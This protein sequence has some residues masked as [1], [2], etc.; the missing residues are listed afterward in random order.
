MLVRSHILRDH[1]LSCERL[2]MRLCSDA[3]DL[4]DSHAGL[5]VLHVCFRFCK[6]VCG[7]CEATVAPFSSAKVVL[8]SGLGIPNERVAFLRS[9]PD[10][11]GL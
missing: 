2:P 9:L 8:D 4:V 5:D 3:D 11:L 7:L 10:A 1:D 6:A